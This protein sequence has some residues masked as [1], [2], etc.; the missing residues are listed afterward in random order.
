MRYIHDMEQR[1][2]IAAITTGA[3]LKRWYWLK[4]EL[5]DEIRRRGLR[6]AGGKFDLL[7][8]LAHFLDTGE[9]DLP[10]PPRRKT[11]STFDWHTEPLTR[12]TII[13][14]SYKNTQNVRRFFV[15]ECGP[16]FRFNRLFMAWM[17]ENAGKTLADAVAEY[18][19]LAQEAAQDGHQSEIA[20][21]NQFNQYT[22]DFLADNPERGMADVR[23]AW[24]WKRSQPSEDG[25][26]RYARSDL[27]VFD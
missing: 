16:A 13:T 17:K 9:P 26:H 19:R 24:A 12:D 8:R 6:Q 21:H 3:E 10:R 22:R 23:R 15:Q 5:L 25:R 20:H 7:D 18:T 11:R 2:D 4:A 14:D 1:P 27:T